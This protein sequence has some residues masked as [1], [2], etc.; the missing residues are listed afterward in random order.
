[1]GLGN[2]QRRG[3]DG[4]A[5]AHHEQP[6]LVKDFPRLQALAE[7]HELTAYDVAYLD[8][9][10]RLSLPLATRDGDLRKAALAEKIELL[11]P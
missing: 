2:S 5:Q 4:E 10:M 8:I 6:P 9:A 1:M 3:C 7:R 11:G